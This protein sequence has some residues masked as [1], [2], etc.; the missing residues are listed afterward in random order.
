MGFEKHIGKYRLGR[1]IGEGT[2]SKVKLA[3]NEDNGEKV[4]IKVIDKHMVMENNLKNQVKREISTMKL[5]H[6]PNIVRIFEVIG[7]KTKIYIVMEYVSGGQVLDKMSYEKK[8]NEHVARKLFQQLIDAMDYCHN[9]G[10]YHRDLK[11]ENLL[12]DSKGNLKVSDFGLSALQ[13]PNDVLNT[14]CGSPCYV[15][16]ELILSKGYDGASADVWS[17]G[18]ILFELL[19]GFLPF[20]D[21]NLMNLYEKICRAAYKCPPWF[22]QSQKKLIA[23]IFVPR[24]GKRITIPDI[25]EDE[26]FQTDYE[27]AC[28]SECDKNIKLDD[29]NVAFDSVEEK[30]RESKIPKSS[31]FINAFQLIAMSQDLDL[32]GLFEE[33]QD[34]KKQ[35][36]R[37]GSKHTINETTEKIEAAATDMRLS[38]EKINNFKIKL[39]PKQMMNRCSRSYFDLSAQLIEVAPTHCVV[40]ISRSAGDLRT[41]TKFCESLSSLLEQKSG[42]TSS[43]E[44]EESKDVADSTHL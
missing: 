5:L 24:P 32:S 36:T 17:C 15:A 20:D 7:T 11:P 31:S 42:L 10:V 22:T 34:H 13:K 29:C 2:F 6:H 9:K 12:L 44:Q 25:I 35:K 41:Y 14:R 8:L 4:A 21:H 39:H 38:V 16:P 3:V 37:F 28:V 27:P 30:I 19:A 33:E 1:T 18:V 23:K 43:Q 26:W 40:E